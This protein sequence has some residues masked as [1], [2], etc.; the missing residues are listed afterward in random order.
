[1]KKCE[2]NYQNQQ[3]A[4]NLNPLTS[5]YLPVTPDYQSLDTL[6]SLNFIG[7]DS[8]SKTTKPSTQ[9]YFSKAYSPYFLQSNICL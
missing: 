1:M 9:T 6:P 8:N 5:T 7:Y 3:R 4:A 2:I